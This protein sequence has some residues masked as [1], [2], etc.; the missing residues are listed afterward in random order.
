MCTETTEYFR[1]L[2]CLINAS[3]LERGRVS[4][5]ELRAVTTHLVT[6]Y[7]YRRKLHSERHSTTGELCPMLACLFVHGS[8][9]MRRFGMRRDRDSADGI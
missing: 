6:D 4:R 1:C 5:T 8:H 9:L 3:L 2:A 7:A